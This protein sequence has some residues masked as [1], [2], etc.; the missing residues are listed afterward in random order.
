MKHILLAGFIFYFSNNILSQTQEW[1][2]LNPFDQPP[3]NT[4]YAVD[5]VDCQYGWAV[6]QW[7]IVLHTSDGGMTWEVQQNHTMGSGL[8]SVDFVDRFHGWI[9]GENG[10][11]LRTNDGG[12][13]WEEAESPTR[14]DLN[15]V[16]FL[17][18]AKG[19]AVGYGGLLLY[20]DDSGGT[21]YTMP[22]SIEK[23]SF[24]HNILRFL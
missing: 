17:D 8:K 10:F 15:D 9:V 22:L 5:F 1:I 6:G 16:I 19:W 3:G 12:Q 2:N 21:W 7:G 4:L 20:A 18:T 24:R 23:F 11:I 14:W 13:S